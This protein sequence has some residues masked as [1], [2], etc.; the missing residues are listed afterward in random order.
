MA[1]PQVA[2]LVER[3]R[4][5]ANKRAGIALGV[6]GEAGIGKSHRLAAVLTQLPC[7]TRTVSANGSPAQLAGSLP[8]PSRLATWV[9]RAITAAGTGP[10]S[11]PA[12]LG[13]AFASWLRALAPFVLLFEDVHAASEANRAFVSHLATAAHGVRGVGLVTTGRRPP[14][15]PFVPVRI[16]ALS[17][18]D[19]ALLLA[20]E[21]GMPVPSQASDWVYAKAAG[22]PLYTLEFLRYLARQGHLWNDGQRWRWRAPVDG[23]LPTSVEALIEQL[24]A[25]ARQDE[26]DGAVL[27][28]RAVLG[29]HAERLVW[30]AMAQLEPDALAASVRRLGQLG[31]FT[32]DDFAHPLFREVARKTV[33]PEHRQGLARR[34][35]NALAARPVLAASFLDDAML[36]REDALR[37]LEAAAAAAADGVTAARLNARAAGYANADDRGRKAVEAMKVLQHHDLPETLRL[38]KLAFESG[39]RP[40]EVVP[41]YAHLL[42]RSG[43]KAELELLLASPPAKALGEARIT[44]LRITSSNVAGEHKEAWSTWLEHPELDA[45]AGAELLR[46]VAASALAVGRVADSKELTRRGLEVA[47]T[48][49]LRC[50]FLS[51]ESLIAF[52]QGDARGAEARIAKAL[53]LLSG[54]HAPRLRATALLNRAAYLRMLGDYESMEAC[55]LECLQIRQGAGEGMA[56]AFALASLAELRVEQGRF[57]EAEDMVT[58]SIATLE[59]YGPSRYLMN[60]RSIACVLGLAQATPLSHLTAL[61]HSEQ[62]LAA[63]RAVGNPRAV[64]EL[65]FDASLANTAVGNPERGL[66]L[67][68]ES[69]ALAEVTGDAPNDAY[70]THWAMALAKEAKGEVAAALRHLREAEGIARDTEGAIDFHKIGLEIARMR[71]DIEAA[72][73]HLAWFE[74]RGLMSGAAL[75]RRHFPALLDDAATPSGTLPVLEVLGPVQ[76]REETVAPVRGDKRRRLLASLLEARVNGRAGVAKLDLI[77]E[78]YPGQDEDKAGSSLKEVVRGLRVAFGAGIVATT[79]GGYALGACTSDLEA[80]LTEAHGALWR[81]PYLDGLETAGGVRDALH[82]ALARHAEDLLAAEPQEA[83]RLAGILVEAEPYQ[84]D[85]LRL[86]LRALRAAGNHRSLGRHYRAACA[87]MAELGDTLPERWQDFLDEVVAP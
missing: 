68:E 44:G 17:A 62:A 72:R 14:T 55:L 73:R 70:R 18:S 79:P 41:M 36:E 82:L 2:A 24:L 32:G 35:V 10:V 33:L 12:N 4:P 25:S 27:E 46:S 47:T 39:Y 43:Q 81:G 78:L 69:V 23:F 31:V 50:E 26:R 74:E 83:A 77:D 51:L 37:L 67:A 54:L 42:A 5:V 76:V 28:A 56:Y 6:W 16:E 57:E 15:D 87:R 34:A 86:H 80:F 53:E 21:V 75:A 40:A 38:A 48:D 19:S 59:L 58:E 61:K 84:L 1:E 85:H 3:L 9:E 49:D 52:H 22:N 63:A 30:S 29:G 64:R 7:H 13:A 66:A 20:S 11:D 71:G 8:R 60:T 45:D 65:L